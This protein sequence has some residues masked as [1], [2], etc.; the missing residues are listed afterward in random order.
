MSLTIKSQAVTKGSQVSHNLVY[1]SGKPR[2][3]KL[4]ISIVPANYYIMPTFC[5]ICNVELKYGSNGRKSLMIHSNSPDLAF[6]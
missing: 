1:G 6:F 3:K 4:T 5:R 2:N